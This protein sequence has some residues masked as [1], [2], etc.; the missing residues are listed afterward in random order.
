MAWKRSGVR[1]SLAPLRKGRSE[2]IYALPAFFIWG[3]GAIVGAIH[4][5]TP[6]PNT[7]RATHRGRHDLGAKNMKQRRRLTRNRETM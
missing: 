4:S 1:F 2:R 7:A 3:E 6:E 5:S